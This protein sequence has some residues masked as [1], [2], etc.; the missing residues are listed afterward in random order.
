MNAAFP[1]HLLPENMTPNISAE[2]L[3]HIRKESLDLY[4]R[5]HSIEE[6]IS[7]VD[8][9]R[10]AYPSQAFLRDI[11][12]FITDHCTLT[13]SFFPANLRCGAW[14]TDPTYVRRSW[15]PHL[16]R[17][18]LGHSQ[19]THPRISSLPTGITATGAST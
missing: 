16:I 7:F 5:L 14:Y 4:N 13:A 17:G 6:D 8:S 11:Q 10:R 1:G 18:D 9:V 15:N 12:L 3:A 2:A 19:G